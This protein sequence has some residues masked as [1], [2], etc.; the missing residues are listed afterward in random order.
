MATPWRKSSR[1][2]GQGGQ[3]VEARTIGP[4]FQL[5]DSKLGNHSPILDLDA[6]DFTALLTTLKA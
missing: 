4:L 1:S 2:G 5:R 6:T 3:C